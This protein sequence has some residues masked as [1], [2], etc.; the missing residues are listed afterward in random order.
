METD[1]RKGSIEVD[2]EDEEFLKIAKM[3]H[4]RDITINQMVEIIFQ[5]ALDHYE[6]EQK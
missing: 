3:A 4:E 1:N 2:L 6:G 5:A